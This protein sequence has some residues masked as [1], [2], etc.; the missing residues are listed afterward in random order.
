MITSNKDLYRP[1]AA[2]WLDCLQVWMGLEPPAPEETPE[3]CQREVIAWDGYI[4]GVADKVM[5]L[6]S[7]GPGQSSPACS[8]I[9]HLQRCQI[10]RRSLL[11]LQSTA[12]P[13]ARNQV[14]YRSRDHHSVAAEPGSGIAGEVQGGV[15][16]CGSG[17]WRVDHQRR[18]LP[19]GKS[20][21]RTHLAMASWDLTFL[22]RSTL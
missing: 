12:G 7:E 22:T 13:D 8:G 20:S 5:E 18:R 21:F 9:S 14:T 1:K 17:S 4:K 6:L 3:V 2:C 11:S 15:D 10:S 16:R 19:T